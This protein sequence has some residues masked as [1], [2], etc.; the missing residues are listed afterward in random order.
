MLNDKE[1]SDKL[2]ASPAERVTQEYMRNRIVEEGFTNPALTPTVTICTLILDN[3]YSV[4]GESACVNPANY[5]PAIGAKIA[6]DDAFKKLWP[7]FGFLLAEKNFV[8]GGTH[9]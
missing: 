5:D 4:R 3:G 7:L 2:A 1:L 8:K 9:A 6:Y